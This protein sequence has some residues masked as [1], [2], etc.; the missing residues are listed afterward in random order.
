MRLN[1][2][3]NKKYFTIAVLLFLVEVI[4][5]LYV[6]DTIIR[7]YVGDVL[8]VILLYCF[9]KSF[10]NTPVFITAIA[11]LIFSYV[12]ETLQYF[13]YVKLLG[14]G[15]SNFANIVMGNY[16]AWNDIIAY[17]IGILMVLLLENNWR[18]K[19]IY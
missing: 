6:H 18:G 7:P 5:G 1:I 8:V 13:Q 14:L 2:E 15:D 19:K 4:I 9:V 10:F 17:T 12:I 11:V 16:F 3:F